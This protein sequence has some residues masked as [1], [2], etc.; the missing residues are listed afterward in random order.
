[1]PTHTPNYNLLHEPWI[2]VLYHDGTYTRIGIRKTL[3]DAARIR[4]IAASSPMDRVALLR[5]LLALLYWSRG[6]PPDQDTTTPSEQF[7]P[8]W[9]SKLDEHKESFNLLGDGERFYQNDGYKKRPSEHTTNYLIQE[10][11]SGT[12]KWHFR[13]SSDL[14]NG[15]CPACCAMGLLRLP[16]FAT[17]AGRGMTPATGKSPGINAKPPVYCFKLGS[18]LADTMKLNWTNSAASLG[19][20][21]WES[22]NQQLQKK[23]QVPLLNGLTWNPRNI[24]LADPDD[25]EGTCISCGEKRRL[26]RRCAF[27]GKGS[28]KADERV[29]HDPY[30]LNFKSPKHDLAPVHAADSLGAADAASG[31]W[32]KI[33]AGLLHTTPNEV[34]KTK[35]WIVG[36]STVQNDKYLEAMELSIPSGDGPADT[37]G[38][39]EETE[40]MRK[41]SSTFL[42]KLTKLIERNPK[43][44]HP[45]VQAILSSIRPQIENAISAKIANLAVGDLAA[46]I[47]AADAYSPLLNAASKSL[48]PGFSTAALKR[49]RDIARAQPDMHPPPPASE[50]KRT[51]K[52]DDK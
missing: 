36:F 50:S 19:T 12:N 6:I 4:Q 28:A 13:H 29:W 46:W 3:E 49:R 21:E 22:P 11:P 27:D 45:E 48:S 17:S 9:F 44:R 8:G 18:S 40:I 34:G 32:A 35:F 1:M 51:K 26:I 37:E 30:V 38:A 33:L 47:E 41:E 5:F 42:K 7:S 14:K 2:P 52:G 25:I 16:A 31:Q 23:G 43:R 20:P 10:V 39:L 15:L 24:W